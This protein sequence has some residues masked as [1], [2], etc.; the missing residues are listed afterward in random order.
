MRRCGRSW[1]ATHR[2]DARVVGINVLI[3]DIVRV[4]VVPIDVVRV[5]IIPIDVV[6]IRVIYVHVV[7]IDVV[8]VH[9]IHVHIIHVHIIPVDVVHVH[10]VVIDVSIDAVV[11]V[12]VVV[13][14]IAIH[15]C[16]VD[17]DSAVPVIHVPAI[18]VNVMG[19]GR[20]PSRSMPTVVVD[21]VRVPIAV[22]VKPRTD[23]Q[24]NTK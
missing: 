1:A 17:V 15:Y 16:R 9:V 8:Y 19:A 3:G 21:S 5:H 10:V 12:D 22:V 23:R 20:Y 6:H 4:H 7:P 18:D 13:I 14:H 2:V 24:S 11:V